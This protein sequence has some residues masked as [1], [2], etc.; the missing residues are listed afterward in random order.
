ME[1]LSDH[2]IAL[3]RECMGIKAEVN[4]NQLQIIKEEQINKGEPYLLK[5]IVP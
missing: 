2:Q 1:R 3:M 5:N 4:D